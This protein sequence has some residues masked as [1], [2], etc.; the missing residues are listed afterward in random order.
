MRLIPRPQSCQ[1]RDE[2]AFILSPHTRIVLGQ[3]AAPV[4]A[5]QVR[6]EIRRFAGVEAAIVRGQAEKGDIVFT[7]DASIREQGYTLAISQDQVSL[8][9]DEK[10]LLHGGQTLRQIIRQSGLALPAL[11][12][13]DSPHFMNRGYFFDVSRGRVST[14]DTLKRIVDEMCFYKLNQFQLYM[15]HTY[16]FRG[17][18]EVWC[19]DTPLEAEEI[20]AL[21]DY[22]F[23]RGIELVPSLA[24]FGHM[25]EILKTKTFEGLCELEAPASFPVY[26]GRMQHHTINAADPASLQLVTGLIDEYLPL[27]RSKQFNICG[28]ETFDLG[29]G[30]G[31]QAMQSQGEKAFYTGF[32]KKLCEYVIEKGS[33]PMMWGDIILRFPEAIKELPKETVFL[34]WGYAPNQREDETRIFAQAGASQ[35]VCPGVG[36][37]NEWMPKLRSSYENITRMCAYGKMHGA[38]GVLNTDWGDFGHVADPL[39]SLPGMIYGAAF[40]WSGEKLPFEAINEDISRLAYLDASGRIIAALAGMEEAV[41]YSWADL[42][43][44]LEKEKPLSVFEQALLIQKQAR[45]ETVKTEVSAC[46]KDMD[47]SMRQMAQPWLIAVEA[48]A[49]W[50]RVGMRAAQ[51]ETDA[52]LAAELEQWFHLYKAAW[53]K[54]A[55]EG[56][57]ML[58]GAVV[59][60][61]ADRLR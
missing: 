52:S 27:F 13:E 42:V 5:R 21:D 57:L 56:D 26:T 53:R 43:V 30:R 59:C 15:E 16:L 24:T 20:M 39:F 61:Y 36:S 55:K 4:A 3:N 60:R 8:C 11:R 2:A 31:A 41:L 1:M 19:K 18:S 23:E 14:L 32:V 33:V 37:W 35:Y 38:L 58:I 25:F 17:L 48:V 34:N 29:K 9:G 46:I 40:C 49:L 6:D 22:C 54:H 10:G 7:L 28:D 45:L 47:S 12:V 50:N 44:H 51:G